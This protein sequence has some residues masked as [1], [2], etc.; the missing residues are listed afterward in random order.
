[1]KQ[2]IFRTNNDW[3][4]LILRMTLGIVMFPHGA[5]KLLGWYGGNGFSNSINYFTEMAHLPLIIAFLVIV[6]EFFGSLSFI[7]GFASRL[8]SVSMIVM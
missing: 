8:W 2:R 6:I 1:M 4:G 7:A 5:Q 3:T